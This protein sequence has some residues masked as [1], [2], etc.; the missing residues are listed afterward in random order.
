MLKKAEDTPLPSSSFHQQPAPSSQSVGPFAI[1]QCRDLPRPWETCQH[2][3]A[4]QKPSFCFP[5]GSSVL[6][7]LDSPECLGEGEILVSLHT[8]CQVIS[9]LRMHGHLISV[10]TRS[11]GE[12]RTVKIPGCNRRCWPA[13]RYTF[14]LP[15]LRARCT[16]RTPSFP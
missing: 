4:I 3:S 11:P 8:S 12:S 10:H 9:R 16:P 15:C 5:S 14:Q 1:H 2:V 6:V 7:P 13:L